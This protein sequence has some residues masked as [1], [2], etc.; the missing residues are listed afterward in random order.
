MIKGYYYI[1]K[2]NYN[3][4]MLT[5]ANLKQLTKLGLYSGPN[6]FFFNF[7]IFFLPI[8]L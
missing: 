1:V 2:N 5:F 6:P 8:E 4:N 3:N 7:I